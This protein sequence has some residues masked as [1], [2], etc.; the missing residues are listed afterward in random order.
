M[1]LA[2]DDKHVL[3]EEVSNQSDRG[4]IYVAT[5]ARY[6]K[7]AEGSAQSVRRWMPEIPTTIWTDDPAR[8]RP[9]LFTEIRKI[10]NPSFSFLDKFESFCGT[11]YAKTLFLDS[12]TLLLGTIHEVF[13]ILDRFDFACAHGPVRGTDSP[14]L[15]AACPAAF[16]EPNT[17][18]IAYNRNA[19]TLGLLQL[20]AERYK[21]QL[22]EISHRK[23]EQPSL[24]R[25]LWE[26]RIRFVT[27]P[28]E[29]NLRT[30]FP[31]FSGRM[32]VKILHGREPALSRAAKK[33]NRHSH[34]IRIYDFSKKTFSDRIRRLVTGRRKI[35][36]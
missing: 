10:E 4:I 12:D 14:E 8:V 27:L 32:P 25:I 22:R 18:V 34:S 15:L 24:R 26:S 17:G 16:V 20:W 23:S 3:V 13:E 7:E 35:K 9:A 6:V 29:Y 5:G 33:I 21:Q 28:P 1:G 30:P 19:E 36:S 11:P 2:I 31:V